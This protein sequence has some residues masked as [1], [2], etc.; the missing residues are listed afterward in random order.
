M[1][2]GFLYLVEIIEWASRAVLAWRL[3]NTKLMSFCAAAL[4]E[5]LL[6]AAR[7]SSPSSGLHFRGRGFHQ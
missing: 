5:A 3:S 6:P 4:E 7:I 2:C 1:A